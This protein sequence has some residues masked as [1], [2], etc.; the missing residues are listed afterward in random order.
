MSKSFFSADRC[1]A[2]LSTPTD[3]ETIGSP[4][5]HVA[6]NIATDIAQLSIALTEFVVTFHNL[7]QYTY[8]WVPCSTRERQLKNKLTFNQ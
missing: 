3:E 7:P 5:L 4:R 1:A 8:L 6:T 2:M